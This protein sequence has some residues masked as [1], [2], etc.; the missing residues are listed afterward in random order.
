MLYP[1]KKLWK[2]AG[3]FTFCICA[4]CVLVVGIG[5][6]IGFWPWGMTE[7]MT[8]AAGADTTHFRVR[9]QPLAADGEWIQGPLLEPAKSLLPC[10]SSLTCY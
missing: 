9:K 1:M 8:A 4:A 6:G 7:A 5:F 10:F 3:V 2:W